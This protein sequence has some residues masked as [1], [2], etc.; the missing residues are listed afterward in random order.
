V[1]NILEVSNLNLTF[2]GIK[3]IEDLSFSIAP[4][5]FVG[6]MG[7]NGAGKTSVINCL[8]RVYAPKGGKIT[9]E[10]KDLLS[11]KGDQ[12]TGIGVTR[13]FQ[14]LNFFSLIPD[15]MVIDYVRLGQFATGVN[16][17]L[18]GGMQFKKLRNREWELKQNARRILEFFREMRESMEPPQVDRGYPVLYGKEGFADL[19]D[20]EHQPIGNLSFAWRRRLDLAR[21]LVSNPKLLLLDEPSQ[22]LSPSEIEK[23]GETLKKIRKEFNVSAL[24]VEHNMAMLTDISDKIIVMNSGKKLIEGLPAEVRKHPIVIEQY[25]GKASENI[26]PEG[27]TKTKA[28]PKTV[29]VV[30]DLD[31][32]YGQA[33]A[34]FSISL[35]LLSNQIAT[36]LGTNGSGKSTLLKAIGGIEK[37][38]FGEILV[39]GEYLPL[40]WP[41]LAAERNIQYVPQGHLIFP[42]LSVYDN[43]KVG[44]H[45]CR[46]RKGYDI[47]KEVDRILH[48]FPLLG[49][50][51]KLEGAKLSGG[52]QQMLAIGQAL[53]ARPEILLLDEP[54]LGLAPIYVDT[55]FRIIRQISLEEGCS[56][57][58]V[59]QN[60]AKALEVSDYI[61]MLNA[62]IMMG[63]GPSEV[64]KAD[65]SIVSKNLG[66]Y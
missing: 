45:L 43:L 7:P 56:I 65:S 33:Q 62:G 57:L 30:K 40:G 52:Q 51:L 47:K 18:A 38:T 1:Q 64:F 16:S 11:L 59:E 46:K 6:I 36:V 39:N 27:V 41:E 23:L 50:I 5:S 20:V 37:P 32:Y 53:M 34:L 35:D 8:S 28:K 22:G 26:K 13:T 42:E 58:M 44:G 31:V 10:G 54:S 15:M 21:A 29:L 12:L 66:F 2:G 25:F 4:N 17:V 49:D 24:I 48:F 63:K 61:Y 55:I 14:D 3:A 19:I 60:V 9:L